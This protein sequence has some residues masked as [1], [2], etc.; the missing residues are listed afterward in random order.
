T[1]GESFPHEKYYT[2]YQTSD[3]L[4]ACDGKKCL[5]KTL[6]ETNNWYGDSNYFIRANSPWFFRG[7]YFGNAAGSGLFSFYFN[8]GGAN[9]GIAFRVAFGF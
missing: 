9:S 4:T 1:N 7:G 5:G 2:L 8:G 6:V 3:K